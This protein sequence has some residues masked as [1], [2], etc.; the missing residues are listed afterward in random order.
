M[1]LIA[2]GQLYFAALRAGA[3]HADVTECART[4]KAAIPAMI[5]GK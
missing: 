2:L 1:L 3:Y 5:D 4:T